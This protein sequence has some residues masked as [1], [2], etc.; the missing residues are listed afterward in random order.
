MVI[1]LE[2]LARSHN[3]NLLHYVF[4]AAC[5]IGLSAAASLPCAN[6]H[7]KCFEAAAAAL[8]CAVEEREPRMRSVVF[9]DRVVTLL[10]RKSLVI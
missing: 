2:E 7:R 5:Q 8:S 4:K 1:P 6:P 9:H 10:G 3:R